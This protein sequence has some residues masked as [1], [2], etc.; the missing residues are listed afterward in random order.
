MNRRQFV[1]ALGAGSVVLGSNARSFSDSVRRKLVA[2]H[3]VVAPATAKHPRNDS[4]SIVELKDG[5]LMGVWMEFVQ[6]EH[7]GHDTGHNRI[8]S[9]ISRDGGLTW[10]KHRVEAVP[11]P[12]DVNIYNPSLLRLKNGEIL[13]SY[14]CYN[15]LSW[16]KPL[17]STGYMHRSRD[18][19]AGFGEPEILWKRQPFQSANNTLVQLSSGRLVRPVAKVPIWGG[20]EDN[21]QSSCMYSDDNGHTWHLPN[22]WIKLPLRGAMEGH[23]AE[24]RSGALLMALRTQLGSV[25]IARSDDGGYSW[26]KAQT[27]GLKSGES[28]PCLVTIPTTGDLLMIWNDSFYDPEFDHFGRRNPLT[29]A[30]SRDEG[31]TWEFR[32][33][34]KDD[35]EWEFSNTACN[36]TSTGKAIITYFSS[37]MEN[38]NPPGRLARTAMSLEAVIVDIDR[39][40]QK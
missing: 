32:Q 14:L 3:T 17:V 11:R 38:P 19:A 18:P 22:N 10:K 12:G 5:Q 24:T 8:V 21:Q 26:R 23:I 36:F 33:N 15:E 25:F 40:Y 29:C 30:V 6:S 7:A 34:I 1:A 4:A 27:S 37:K 35:P 2:Q 28:M 13:F 20:A 9:K 16:R 31:N 39:F